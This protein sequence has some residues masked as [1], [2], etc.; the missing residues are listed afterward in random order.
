M[1][2]EMLQWLL[3]VIAGLVTAAFVLLGVIP[4]LIF[5]YAKAYRYG[6]LKADDLNE[7]FHKDLKEQQ[8]G[9]NQT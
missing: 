6:V 1:S 8:H 9:G 2:V 3:L 4:F 5:V 7:Q